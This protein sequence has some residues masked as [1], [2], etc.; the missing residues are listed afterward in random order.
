MKTILQS[1]IILLIFLGL[2]IPGR[3]MEAAK[4]ELLGLMF[5][6]EHC[7][8]CKILDPK[9]QAAAEEVAAEP[10]LFTTFD[11]SDDATMAQAAMLATALGVAE[12]YDAQN[13]ASGFLLLVDAESKKPVGKI[14]RDMSEAEIETAIRE[15]L[16]N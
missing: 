8:S 6:S 10:V 3:A 15:A 2:A 14:T 11:H 13:K 7:G 5:F 1:T 16:K 12:V 9:V 4:P